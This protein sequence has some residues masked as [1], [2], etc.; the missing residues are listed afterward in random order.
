MGF[1][2]CRVMPPRELALAHPQKVSLQIR[3]TSLHEAHD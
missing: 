2:R 1:A 3:P